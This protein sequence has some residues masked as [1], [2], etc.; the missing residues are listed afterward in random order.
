MDHTQGMMFH[1]QL[2]DFRPF[3]MESL[4]YFILVLTD[5]ILDN[6]LAPIPLSKMF[7]HGSPSGKERQ[8]VE[9]AFPGVEIFNRYA[10]HEFEGIACACPA[11]SGMHI[12]IDS[13]FVE[14]IREDNS[15][16]SPGEIARLIITDLDNRAMPLIRYE[17]RDM[18]WH[19]NER[20]PCGR[21]L[22]LM[23]DLVGRKNEYV[24]TADG[25]KRYFA[26]FH[27]FFDQYQEVRYFQ[28]HQ[29]GRGIVE[30]HVVKDNAT[31]EKALSEKLSEALNA[32]LGTGVAVQY[33]TGIREEKNGKILPV[34]RTN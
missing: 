8:K 29:N 22:P 13:Y 6:N 17:I 10:S 27:D 11:H 1:Q 5:F 30:A 18:A 3:L 34:K 28:I 16:A 26:F 14:F 9:K 31:D 20:C 24:I 32:H 4:Y 19:I 33:V 7:M 23:S 2:R 21:G 15:S 12:S 25:K